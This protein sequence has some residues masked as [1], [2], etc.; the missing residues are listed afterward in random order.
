MNP[1]NSSCFI[2]WDGDNI[3]RMVGRSILSDDPNQ[4]SSISN[5]ISHGNE[6]IKNWVIGHGGEIYSAG[7]DQGAASIP[8]EAVV[9]LDQIRKDY[10]FYTKATLTIGIGNTLSESGKAL[11]SG[12][13]RGKNICVEYDQSVE[14]DLQDAYVKTKAGTASSEERKLAEAYL[15]QGEVVQHDRSEEKANEYREMGLTPPAIEKPQPGENMKLGLGVP[16]DT[17]QKDTTNNKMIDQESD[18]SSQE[19]LKQ[20]HSG[21]PDGTDAPAVDDIHTHLDAALENQKD[22][23]NQMPAHEPSPKS[24]E[25]G[26][27]EEHLDAALEN[28]QDMIDS[29]SN[30]PIGEEMEENVSRPEGF[31]EKQVPGDMGL[32]EDDNGETPDLTEVLRGGLD[33]QADQ[34]KKDKV[35]Q[36]TCQALE[37][38]K[39]NK[40]ILERA[41][42]KAPE[43]YESCIA[44]LRAMIEMSKMLGFGEQENP[45]EQPQEEQPAEEPSPSPEEQEPKQ[46]KPSQKSPKDDD[47]PIGKPI[48]KLPTSHSTPHV[49]KEPIP[50]G[51]VN[52]K[53]QQ[54]VTDAQGIVRF[55]D[56]K[57]PRVKGPGGVP[58]KPS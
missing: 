35:I 42:E 15:D 56:R 43:L 21:S 36:L 23:L 31:D 25:P 48:G 10:S 54:K 47:K 11:L 1:Q 29:N 44:M 37:G 46:Q 19:A 57:E 4:L 26:S 8:C 16:M 28:Q 49:A 9:E 6:I 22:M 40:Q 17:G 39:A 5:D 52:A 3:G 50:E 2:S 33:S 45:L 18:D 24:S 41:Q 20:R 7:G 55:I 30:L 34:I 13:F 27:A 51:G 53:G 32:S 12:K 58:V 38:F 14:Q